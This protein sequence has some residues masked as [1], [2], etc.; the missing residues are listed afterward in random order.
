MSF[1]RI[2]L[3]EDKA[4]EVREHQKR[5]MNGYNAELIA[6]ALARMNAD[7]DMD[8]CGVVHD[9]Q[10][11]LYLAESNKKVCLLCAKEVIIGLGI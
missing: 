2:M 10:P 5:V 3:G 1:L 7:L 11:F 4:K 9:V 8:Y 6:Q